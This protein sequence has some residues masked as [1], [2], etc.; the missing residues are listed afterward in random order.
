LIVSD[1]DVLTVSDYDVLTY[2]VLIVLDYDALTVSDYDVF[3][4]KHKAYGHV[5]LRVGHRI[6][7]PT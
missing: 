5:L 1:Y 2:D 3:D 4:E 7:G 6:R